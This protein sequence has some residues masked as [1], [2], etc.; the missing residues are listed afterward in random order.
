MKCPNCGED[1][2]NGQYSCHKCHCIVE[3]A[4]K[5]AKKKAEKEKVKEK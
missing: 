2:F 5:E 1:L 4:M 3:I